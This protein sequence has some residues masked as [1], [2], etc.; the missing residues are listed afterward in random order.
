MCIWNRTK[1]NLCFPKL[2]VYVCGMC[3]RD[4]EHGL[5][6]ENDFFYG[7]ISHAQ[8]CINRD[9]HM[10]YN[11]ADLS[12]N[13]YLNESMKMDPKMYYMIHELS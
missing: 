6:H 10:K 8:T 9:I 5:K 4:F 1:D 3:I 13:Y 2:R 12:R 11:V 7:C